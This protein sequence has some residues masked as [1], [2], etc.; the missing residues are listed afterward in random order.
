[1]ADDLR[2]RGIEIDVQIHSWGTVGT[3]LDPDG[4]MCELKNADDPYFT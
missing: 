4:N 1:V 2:Q 3:F